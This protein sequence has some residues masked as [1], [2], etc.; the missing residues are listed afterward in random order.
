V[1]DTRKF[2]DD[3]ELPGALC[4]ITI[5]SPV[6]SGR[7][8]SI[9]C[10][11]LPK[12][13][14]LIRAEDIPGKNYLDEAG[15]PVLA[16]AALSYIGEP[17][18]LLLGTDCFLTEEL[19]RQCRVNAEPDTPLFYRGG[20]PEA[21]VITGRNVTIGEVED[22]FKN[23][24][25]VI[26]GVYS[27]GA[28]EHWYS[29]PQGAQA[30]WFDSQG[31]LTRSP[32]NSGGQADARGEVITELR[33]PSDPNGQADAPGIKVF[34]ATQW[35]F[36]V[37]RCVAE[38]LGVPA[39]MVTVEPAR[40][41]IHLDGKLWYPS[42]LACHAALG[43]YITKRPVKLMLSRREDF[44]Y[45]PKRTP[46]EIRIRSALGE[47][48]RLL[49]SEITAVTDMG[50]GK[51][52]ADETLDQCCLG[53]LGVYRQQCLKIDGRAVSTNIP[54]TG[55][56]AG[57]GMA[58]G[59]F[60]MERHAALIT[61][62]LKLDPVEWRK[63]NLFSQKKNL[64]IG[65]PFTENIFA[66]KLF[67]TAAAMGDYNRK[68]AAYE[69][70]RKYRRSHG[71]NEKNETLRGIG[72]AIAYQVNGLLHTAGDKGVHSA[73]LTLDKD[74]SLE[75]RTS[76]VSSNS[77][78]ILIW[79]NIAAEIL[80]LD[81]AS[82]RVIAGNTDTTPDSG[83]AC[84]SRTI[85]TITKL[86][87]LAAVA[88]R[89]Q[90]FRDPLPITVRRSCKPAK[91]ASWGLDGSESGCGGWIDQSAFAR[92]G[93]GAAVVEVEIDP[94]EYT[95]KI[96][97]VWMSV[98][99]GKILSQRQAW[100]SVRF[101]II[102]ALGWASREKVNYEEGRIPVKQFFGYGLPNLL[103]IPPIHI[104]FIWNDTVPPKGIGD[105]P[106]NCIPA[107][108]V[109]AISQATDHHFE[110]LPVTAEDIWNAGRQKQAGGIPS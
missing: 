33:S 51:A 73:E 58:Q 72:I 59:F 47:K 49:A 71:G 11:K 103:E 78:Y 104:D 15:V 96:R 4:G 42:L 7:L 28:Q 97:G 76:M 87:E 93:W 62:T 10:P 95:P 75:I 41:G 48:G 20:F 105:V 86:V 8:V 70:L 37:K 100:R 34:T 64:A 54:P 3:I 74:S 92:S 101:S 38:T 91:T 45:S 13:Y 31:K 52:F 2:V 79:Q 68:W 65:A 107:A 63:D 25:S 83:P 32:S 55:P 98:D 89:K 60:A 17:V 19:A 46:V 44:L 110:R 109:Q 14:T 29:E 90:R 81:P 108:F 36:Q 26:E 88:I 12:N 35:P 53:S 67:D 94:V 99:G 43:A 66:E 84:L 5:R 21:P 50:A 39:S 24:V 22:A 23:A 1:D 9:D 40:I 80:A 69:T 56:F 18:A 27:T 85:T 30:A 6:A 57:F 102:Q 16:S 82:I 77:E 106:F 61:D